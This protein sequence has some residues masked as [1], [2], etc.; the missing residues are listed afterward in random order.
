[1]T[2]MN[3]NPIIL[4]VSCSSTRPKSLIKLITKNKSVEEKSSD[5]N[6]VSQSWEIDTK[7]YTA[8]VDILGINE[9]FQRSE[10]FTN[11][12][13]A[14]IIHM[15]SN[16]DTGLKDIEKWLTL[17]EECAPEIKLLLANYCTGDTKV[18]KTAAIEWCLE[19]GFELIEI[20][21]GSLVI[22]QDII[23]EKVGVDRVIEALQAHTWPNL[24]MKCKNQKKG[25]E[26]QGEESEKITGL[27]E[28]LM[29]TEGLD[30]FSDLFAQLSI[31]KDSLQSLPFNQRKQCAE[32][33]VTAFWKAIGGD[34]D[35][36]SDN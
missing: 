14:L 15:D 36:I 6:L 1:M 16:K 32:Q 33:V 34:E 24:V 31:M 7:Y 17:E 19:R 29:A 18:T 28:E 2:K 11:N 22:D 10:E 35:E 23:E 27:C 20:Y 5:P 4:I 3:E 12:V 21:P 13:E 26:E 25:G 9:D 8:Q 30:E